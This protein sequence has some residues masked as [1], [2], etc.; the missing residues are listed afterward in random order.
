VQAAI[1]R[2]HASGETLTQLEW[3]L[4]LP[5]GET[6]W[7]DGRAIISFGEDGLPAK[8]AGLVLDIDERK[9]QELALVEAERAA[10]A[11]AEAKSQFLANMSHEIRTPMNGV[12]GVLHLLEQ[13]NLSEEGRYL[14]DEA[15]NCGRM[16][17]QLL[18][19]VIDFSRIEAGRL[20][21]SPEPLD[22]GQVL[23]SVAGLL[24]PNATTKG[25]TLRASVPDGPVWI[26]A[27]PV[28]LRQAL[29]N[30]IG[31]AVK[32]TND[33]HVEV[34]LTVAG[35]GELLN[36]RFEIEDTGVGIPEAVQ[37]TLFRR[38]QQADGSTSRRFGGSG[39]GLA[40]TRR[41]AEL[42]DGEVG[43]VSREG[44]GSTFWF[45]ITAPAAEPVK[46]LAEPPAPA[47]TGLHVLLVEDNPTNRLV[48][49]KMLE[50]MG[51]R[52]TMAADGQLGVEAALGSRPDLILMDVQMPVMDGLEATRA[53][54]ALDGDVAKVPIVGLTANAMSHQQR[55]YLE[56]GM[57]GV[58]A[59]PI[60]P[61]ALIAEIARVMADA[62]RAS[63]NTAAA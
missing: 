54:R 52:V 55:A 16:L 28:R 60:S 5:S 26:H 35:E 3:R 1:D 36:L 37:A 2:S 11:A 6:R 53:I 46:A 63:G 14:L 61:A 48:A 13:E 8:L 51:V 27:D 41:L 44:E 10:Q 9:R 38:F 40:I 25:L 22:A 49:S 43:F 33:G 19:D 18:N 42:M 24:R 15:S 57:S 50:A 34:R 32:F 58:V 21:L 4:V 12:L 17:A 62:D 45:G 31:N 20:E 23:R 59:K 29:F 56:A 30:L 7:I 39:L 47:L